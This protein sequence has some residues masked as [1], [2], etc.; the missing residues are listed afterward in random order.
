MNSKY[1]KLVRQ[2][3][4]IL[5]AVLGFFASMIWGT[6]GMGAIIGGVT[7]YIYGYSVAWTIIGAS[8]GVICLYVAYK[9][10]VSIDEQP[11][12]IEFGK[13][14][15]LKD[16]QN[17]QPVTFEAPRQG[18][19]V[20]FET[21]EEVSEW[22]EKSKAAWKRL[23]EAAASEGLENLEA[24][25]RSLSELMEGISDR[26]LRNSYNALK[27]YEKACRDDKIASLGSAV[28]SYIFDDTYLFRNRAFAASTFL[29]AKHCDFLFE[30]FTILNGLHSSAELI[31]EFNSK[32]ADFASTGGEAQVLY[33]MTVR[34]IGK[35]IEQAS[36]L[37]RQKQTMENYL[38]AARI[39]AELGPAAKRWREKSIVHLIG[40]SIGLAPFIIIIILPFFY[41]SE[42]SRFIQT[43]WNMDA[44]TK[45][46]LTAW[47]EFLSKAPIAAT[48]FVTVPALLL[49]WVL[50]HFSRVFVQNLSL[51]AESSNR[52]AIADVYARM[53]AE[54]TILTPEQQTIV[55]QSLFSSAKKSTE[56]DT[57]PSN[58][59]E[60][61]I[62]LAKTKHA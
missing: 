16:G 7:A 33:D 56:E 55:M 15:D 40:A 1:R 25:A 45:E 58:V 3:A 51:A 28:G 46:H 50:K 57:I 36:E 5:V 39:R 42:I 21:R 59:V 62:N 12:P 43:L 54:G 61:L 4:P 37:N 60:Q 26:V 31:G 34:A 19:A 32:Y 44:Q 53:I 48:V 27:G 11:L 2:A 24:H 30:G 52:A 49:A 38:A 29:D 20:N 14:A 22:L 17:F 10:F 47:T 41:G 13:L 8:I 23:Q 18:A 35:Q 9:T 6:I